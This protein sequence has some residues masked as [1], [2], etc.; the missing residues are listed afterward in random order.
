MDSTCGIE[1][2][3]GEMAHFFS[4]DLHYYLRHQAGQ[5][6]PSQRCF[7]VINFYNTHSQCDKKMMKK[8]EK[9][10]RSKWQLFRSVFFFFLSSSSSYTLDCPKCATNMGTIY[11]SWGKEHNHPGIRMP[12]AIPAKS[13]HEQI[14]SHP[15][16]NRPEF[17]F[18][19]RAPALWRCFVWGKCFPKWSPPPLS[20]SSSACP[21]LLRILCSLNEWKLLGDENRKHFSLFALLVFS[22]VF[23]TIWHDLARQPRGRRRESMMDEPL[24]LC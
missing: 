20:L 6:M 4:G 3:W 5:H 22:L 24:L 21:M 23:N 18:F 15:Y 11:L 17:L 9:P 13:I 12:L 7:P 14:N 16:W 8:S 10:R 19:S 1:F 2:N